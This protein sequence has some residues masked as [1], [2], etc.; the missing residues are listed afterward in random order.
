[1][2]IF[3]AILISTHKSLLRMMDLLAIDFSPRELFK[4]A[5]FFWQFLSKRSLL[6]TIKF[7]GK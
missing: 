7:S 5:E 1:M 3:L 6:I 2:I 4:Y